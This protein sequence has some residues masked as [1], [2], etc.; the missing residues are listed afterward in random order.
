[1]HRRTGLVLFLLFGLW[2]AWTATK[3][4]TFYRGADVDYRLG[5]VE[6]VYFDCGA[7]LPIVFDGEYREDVPH[8]LEDTCERSARSHFAW[9]VI[10]GGLAAGFGIAGLFGRKGPRTRPMDSVLQP[11]PT[12]EELRLWD[13]R[14]SGARG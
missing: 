5:T 6:H 11:L 1:M 12:P 4:V 3:P 10:L 7:V 8:W 14:G 9:L 2:V 13:F